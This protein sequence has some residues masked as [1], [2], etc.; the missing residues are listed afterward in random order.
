MALQTNKGLVMQR[1]KIC[2][3]PSEAKAM[4]TSDHR[5]AATEFIRG[6]RGKYKHL[7]LMKALAADRKQ[8]RQRH[9]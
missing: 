4:R 5:P 6:L 7:D 8:D 9:R 3:R 2:D 1:K